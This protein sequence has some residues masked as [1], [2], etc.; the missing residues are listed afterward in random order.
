MLT[1]MNT[2]TACGLLTEFMALTWLLHLYSNSYDAKHTS[3]GHALSSLKKAHAALTGS[4]VG[5][6]SLGFC[7]RPILTRPS[8]CLR[9][10]FILLGSAVAWKR[11]MSA[12]PQSPGN[13]PAS[14]AGAHT[15]YMHQRVLH[16]V[17]SQGPA[18]EAIWSAIYA[19]AL[20]KL[21]EGQGV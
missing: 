16:L 1:S 20:T 19:S 15:A 8:S 10:I 18:A 6:F 7:I 21:T 2:S 13:K 14:Q 9:G 5:V 11:Y 4:R 17:V 3:S 12:Y